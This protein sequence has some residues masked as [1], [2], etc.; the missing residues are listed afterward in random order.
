MSYDPIFKNVNAAPLDFSSF[1]LKGLGFMNR[2]LNALNLKPCVTL[3]GTGIWEFV[4]MQKTR[5]LTDL[6]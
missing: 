5:M 2:K 6:H 1:A 3:Y 4:S